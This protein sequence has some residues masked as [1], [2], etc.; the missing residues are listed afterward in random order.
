M[1]MKYLGEEFDIHTGAV[2]NRFP[3][4][5]N[6][7]AQSEAATGKKFVR[8]WL[9]S[10]FLSVSGAE[11]H[12]S[13]G[14]V[15][16]LSDLFKEGWDAR[17]VRLFLISARYRDPVELTQARLEQA[18][19][20]KERMQDLV[21]RLR[22][23]EAEVPTDSGLAK[24]LLAQFEQAMDDDLNTPGALAAVFSA[25]KSANTLMDAGGMGK[26]EAR[27]VLEALKKVDSVL[28]V[29]K[30]EEALLPERLAKLIAA[31]DE[32]RRMRDFAAADRIRAQLLEEGIVLEDSPRGT[33]W[34]RRQ[35]S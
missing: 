12:K 29:L 30:F 17:S 32:A 23:V 33:L 10:A 31:R 35:A 11:M 2:D 9:H 15:V 24:D 21:G 19:A 4:H 34:K 6:E 25:V 18:K 20:E 5:E 28:G 13:I 3:H 1:S 22:T 14:N 27:V 16:Y 7:I 26:G 8:F